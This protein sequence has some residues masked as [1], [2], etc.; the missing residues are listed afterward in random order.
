MLSLA[1]E[2]F[3]CAKPIQKYFNMLQ[4]CSIGCSLANSDTKDPTVMQIRLITK[5]ALF[6]YLKILQLN[7]NL[8]NSVKTLMS[9]VLSLLQTR[10]GNNHLK[11]NITRKKIP[12]WIID[13]NKKKVNKV[14]KVIKKWNKKNRLL[15][16][17]SLPTEKWQKYCWDRWAWLRVTA[18]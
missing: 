4:S 2:N 10:E 5:S 11:G 8:Q 3:I 1:L 13:K 14:R 16:K 7:H 6:V 12:S 15:E 9:I 18:W 17:D